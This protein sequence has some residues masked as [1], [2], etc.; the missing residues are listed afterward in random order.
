M[1]TIIRPARSGDRPAVEAIVE[2]AYGSYIARIGRKPGPMLDD[3]SALIQQGYVHVLEEK[4]VIQGF[5]VLIQQ[6]DQMLLDN[7]AVSPDA[8]GRGYG[9]K[10]LEFGEQ[11]TRDA[12]CGSMKLYTNEAMTENLSLYARIGYI[13]TH[14]AE[15]KGLR[16]V[17]MRKLLR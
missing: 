9:R 14:R 10:L 8:Q 4:G 13:E 1:T 6:Q 17:Y 2:A 3:Y 11:M 16:R 5:A 7:I 12:G 15:E